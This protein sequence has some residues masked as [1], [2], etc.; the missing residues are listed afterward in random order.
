MNSSKPP[1][2]LV[3]LDGFGFK[4]EQKDNAI[5]QANMPNWKRWLTIYPNILLKASGK[6]VGLP[7]GCIGNSEVG[8]LTIGAGRIIKSTLKK[9][10]EYIYS[11]DFYKNNTIIKNIKNTNRLHILGLLSDAGV[12]SHE[13]HMYAVIKLASEQGVDNIYIHAFLDGRDTPKR[14]ASK[15]LNNLESV[16]K[17]YNATI[18]SLHGRFYA[19]DRDNNWDRT[20]KSYKTMTTDQSFKD[21]SWQDS[22]WQDVLANT[23]ETDEFI[24][25][26][27]INKDGII[28]EGDG[29]IFINFRPDRA[30]QI[31][32]SFIKKDFNKFERKYIPLEFFISAIKYRDDFK[33]EV[34]MEKEV[35][36]D[37]LLDILVNKK[38]LI[39]AE[40][41]KYAHV[42]YFF[43]GMKDKPTPNEKRILIPSLKLKTYEQ[44]PEMSAEKITTAV[45]N[46]LDNHEFF[47]VNYANA[48]MVG[49][50]G[51]FNATVKA[52]EF[53]DKQLLILF[54]EIVEK[55]NGVLIITSDHGN[56]EELHSYHTTNDVPFMVI[57]YQFN[58]EPLHGTDLSCI[59]SI[60]LKYLGY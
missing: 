3:I 30:I 58:E 54:K 59:S 57:N 16:C 22:S 55:R 31:T 10:D 4:S 46:E 12:H 48:D 2:A 26:V 18:A 6:Y 53:L 17:K 14:S 40:S 37:T 5:A 27:L 60:V 32:E 20:E 42:T 56:A 13:R 24:E 1:I 25:P 43:K 7:D 47:L 36:N 11:G 41:E 23:D 52:C 38:V 9:L 28:K 44:H 34:I 50:S 19:M 29:I 35:I 15:Y 45:V 39:C 21:K 8:H 49:H 33:N 51:N